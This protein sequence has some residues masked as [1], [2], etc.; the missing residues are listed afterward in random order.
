[1]SI[2]LVM[3]PYHL[4]L[5]CPLLL[6]PSIFPSFRVFSNE[7][8]LLIKWPKYWGFSFNIGPSNED[9]GLI[10]F[11]VRV[12]CLINVW[13]LKSHDKCFGVSTP[14]MYETA[15]VLCRFHRS[16]VPSSLGG[17]ARFTSAVQERRGDSVSSSHVPSGQVKDRKPRSRGTLDK[18]V[19]LGE[20]NGTPLQYFCLENPMGGE[21]W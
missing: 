2:E 14:R 15:A 5:C 3:P 18:C 11:R 12:E 9:S 8:A 4:I 16:R 1:M 7:S 19:S 6:P 17:A 10:S 21:A 13:G 20:G